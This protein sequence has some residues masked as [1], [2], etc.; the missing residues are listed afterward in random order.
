MKQHTKFISLAVMLGVLSVGHISG[1]QPIRDAVK[2]A[3]QDL[4]VQFESR[5]IDVGE[6]SLHVVFAG[7][8]DGDPVIFL[9]GY[10]EFWYA[11]RG[12]MKVLADKGYRVIAPDQRGYNQSEKPTATSAYRIDKLAGDVIGLAN[13]LGYEKVNLVGHDFGGQ[14]AWW[15]TIFSPERIS[16]LAII[17]KEHPYAYKGFTSQ[18]DEV[19]WYSRLLQVPIL[20]GYLAR[21][22]NW[23]LLASA[24]RE[25]SLPNTFPDSEMDQYR[26]AWDNKGAIHSMAKWYRANDRFSKNYENE[27]GDKLIDVPTLVVLAPNDAFTPTDLTARSILFLENG[28]VINLETGTH[29]VIH[30]HPKLLANILGD[31]FDETEG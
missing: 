27:L 24:M 23:R 21:I 25:T 11:W 2:S 31:F 16:K 14:V 7:P 10:P 17:N 12:S 13:V 18:D 22:G 8:A 1:N 29:W 26:S 3:Q 4:G 6:V 20:P 28:K 15:T 30:E 9:H 19:D 5:M